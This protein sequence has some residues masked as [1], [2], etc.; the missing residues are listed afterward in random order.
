MRP[1]GLQA[2]DCY[3][4]LRGQPIQEMKPRH[5]VFSALLFALLFF[6]PLFSYSGDTLII[7]FDEAK[8]HI[9]Q[10]AIVKGR[11]VQVSLLAKAVFLD[12]GAANPD[13]VFAAISH[14]LPFSV[15]S[16]FEGKTVSV[17]GKIISYKGKPGIIIS[18]FTQVVAIDE[19]KTENDA[20]SRIYPPG[21]AP[22][23][24]T[25]SFNEIEALADH[26]GVNERLYLTGEFRVTAS[27]G[28]RAV[29]RDAQR[30]DDQSPRIVVEYPTAAIPPREKERLVRDATRPYLIKGVRQADDVITVYVREIT[31]AE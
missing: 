12:F 11:V 18:K 14:S 7:N 9:G 1:T 25:L 30:P 29:L 19:P 31:S 8:N 17:S 26:G 16:A 6:F 24:P 20:S 2:Q 23:A 21:K 27:S 15:L 10:S 28:N 5:P 22:P 3:T 13:E 4:R